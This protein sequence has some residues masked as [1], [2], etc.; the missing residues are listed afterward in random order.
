MANGYIRISR[1]DL[2]AGEGGVV[3]WKNGGRILGEVVSCI[4]S[5]ENVHYYLKTTNIKKAILID[6]FVPVGVTDYMLYSD[7]ANFI[8]VQINTEDFTDIGGGAGI[9]ITFLLPEGKYYTVKNVEAN[10][11]IKI[12]DPAG[13]GGE[14]GGSGLPDT[15]AASAGDVLSLDVDKAPV[16]ATPAS[17]ELWQHLIFMTIKNAG[18]TSISALNNIQ[19]Q[20]LVYSNSSTIDPTNIIQYAANVFN[21]SGYMVRV[22]FTGGGVNIQYGNSGANIGLA[23]S[24]ANAYGDITYTD[25][26]KIF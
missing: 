23:P 5:D 26:K 14:I 20:C 22:L 1:D 7:S 3:Y 25:S 15:L 10:G 13:D 6:A 24:A 18:T 8:N 12:F 11:D 16:W 2:V 21:I 4:D 19:L 9:S 17:V